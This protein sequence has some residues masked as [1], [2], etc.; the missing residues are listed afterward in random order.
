LPNE[1]VTIG[2]FPNVKG[3]MDLPYKPC[4]AVELPEPINLGRCN[5]CEGKYKDICED[6]LGYGKEYKHCRITI[7]SVKFILG[8]N[9]L[10]L[11]K[12]NL[13]N[14][15]ITGCINN[16]SPVKIEFDGGV[17]YLMPMKNVP[18]VNYYD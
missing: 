6:C 1:V 9:Y 11:I 16:E 14:A 15:K 18:Q 2:A 12:D 3:V 10:K 17:C 5:I 7:Q 13:P 4:E 8:G